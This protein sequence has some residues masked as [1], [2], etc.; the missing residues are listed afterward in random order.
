MGQ[1]YLISILFEGRCI[2]E[3]G[4]TDSRRDYV[5]LRGTEWLMAGL[6]TASERGL[7][8]LA[9]GSADSRRGSAGSYSISTSARWG[10]STIILAIR[11]E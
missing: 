7:Q 2:L 4:K 1:L 9:L 6:G 8:D 10:A 5:L 11:T 3:R